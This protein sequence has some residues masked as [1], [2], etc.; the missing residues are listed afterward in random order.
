M[1][2]QM[3]PAEAATENPYAAP[4][5]HVSDVVENLDQEL[6]DRG[7]RLGAV[8]LDGLVI[9]V[10]VG[11]C[12]IVAAIAAGANKSA[13]GRNVGVLVAASLMACV[14]IAT[15]IVNF[16]WLRRYGQTVGKRWLK[17]KI[18]RNDGTQA[19]LARIFFLRMLPLSVVGGLLNLLFP[20]SSYLIRIADALFIFRDDRR[21]VHDLIADTKVVK[22]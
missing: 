2:S 21:C 16:I 6:A 5:A 17:I 10:P 15:I 14:L 18:V 9:G 8:I 12:A 13:P 11:V 7:T 1:S 19:G 22:V 4:T 20:F 3:P